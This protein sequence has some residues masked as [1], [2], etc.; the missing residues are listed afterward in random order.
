VRESERE[1][2]PVQQ[3]VHEAVDAL[4]E[5]LRSLR[6]QA[7]GATARIRREAR[8]FEGDVVRAR[9]HIEERLG[10]AWRALT[11]DEPGAAEP[12][13]RTVRRPAPQRTRRRGRA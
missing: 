4:S 11:Q 10:R 3:A 9:D 7:R 13:R 5:V 1:T 12:A 2:K 6:F 8:S